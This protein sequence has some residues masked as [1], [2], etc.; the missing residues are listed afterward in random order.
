MGSRIFK[1]L[2]YVLNCIIDI[3]F[4]GME[5]CILCNSTSSESLLCTNC[6]QLVKINYSDYYLKDGKEEFKCYSLGFYSYSIKKLILALKYERNFYAAKIMGEYVTEFIKNK[7]E[8][9]IDEITFVPSSKEAISTRG[10]NQC[11]VI[12]NQVSSEINIPCTALLKKVKTTKDQIGLSTA[13]RWNN[14]KD[15]FTCINLEYIKNKNILLIDDVVTT[16][17]TA[18]YCASV[19]KKFGAKEVYVLTVAKSRV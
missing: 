14:I 13:E 17:A 6:R 12:C 3:I 9:D 5:N 16:G 11:E 19:L 7:L 1:A 2:K 8:E 18:F 10:F 4:C 15:S